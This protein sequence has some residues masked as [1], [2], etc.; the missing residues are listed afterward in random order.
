MYRTEDHEARFAEFDYVP[1]TCPTADLRNL[2]PYQLFGRVQEERGADSAKDAYVEWVSSTNWN[3]L[4]TEFL[5]S[6]LPDLREV[7]TEGDNAWVIK[8]AR[9]LQDVL[10]LQN[11]VGNMAQHYMGGYLLHLSEGMRLTGEVRRK[12]ANALIPLV[13][14]EYKDFLRRCG[15]ADCQ[16]AE[17]DVTA[18]PCVRMR[19][20]WSSIG[21][22]CI[23]TDGSPSD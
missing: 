18:Y 9:H 3:S 11:R 13:E 15:C 22:H 1:V 12:V 14:T 21:A 7:V 5:F 10:L 2:T 23:R 4:D 20:R 6:P 16:Q 19:V 17:G 8:H